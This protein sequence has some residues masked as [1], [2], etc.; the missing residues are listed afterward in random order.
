MK[1]DFDIYPVRIEY[2]DW[3]IFAPEFKNKII[4]DFEKGEI[5]AKKHMTGTHKVNIRYFEIAEDDVQT[6]LELVSIQK[7]N[8]YEQL[9]DSHKTDLGYRDGWHT[10]YEVVI[11]NAKIMIGTLSNYYKECPLENLLKFLKEHYPYIDIL[12]GL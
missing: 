4:V 8:E 7:L 1:F 9:P 11:K 6:M 2:S 10:N 3:H 5:I 12:S